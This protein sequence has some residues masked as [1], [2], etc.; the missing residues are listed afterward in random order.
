MCPAVWT[1]CAAS[2]RTTLSLCL[3]HQAKT[4][5]CSA[6]MAPHEEAAN[7]TS[8]SPAI[9]LTFVES[10]YVHAIRVC[11][12]EVEGICVHS[13]TTIKHVYCMYLCAVDVNEVPQCKV[14][15]WMYEY[16][17][18][19]QGSTQRWWD[20]LVAIGPINTVLHLHGIEEQ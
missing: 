5:M 18:Q 11:K 6:V 13:C 19:E 20:A 9:R 17:L 12:E 10:A 3:V 15:V 8:I 16:V 1:Y 4:A 7:N 2:N 14:D